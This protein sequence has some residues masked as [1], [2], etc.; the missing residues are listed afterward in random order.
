[1]IVRSLHHNIQEMQNT[2]LHIE[3]KKYSPLGADRFAKRTGGP[4]AR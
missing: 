1:M 4:V 2:I 3:S